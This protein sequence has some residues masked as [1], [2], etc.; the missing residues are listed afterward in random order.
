MPW[1]STLAPSLR[2]PFIHLRWEL[3]IRYLHWAYFQ[4]IYSLLAT[5]LLF[6][7]KQMFTTF[8]AYIKIYVY[9]FVHW[10]YSYNRGWLVEKLTVTLNIAINIT[11]KLNVIVYI[12][13][14]EPDGS[15]HRSTFFISIFLSRKMIYILPC[16]HSLLI[17][18]KNYHRT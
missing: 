15:F 8:I 11:S 9:N 2:L 16:K 10:F 6:N 12:T 7:S 14:S 1:I 3:P 13:S 5:S 17:C 4:N 18:F